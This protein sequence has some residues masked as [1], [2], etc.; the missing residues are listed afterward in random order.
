MILGFDWLI[1]NEAKIDLGD[2]KALIL[3]TGGGNKVVVPF[4]EK[5][6]EDSPGVNLQKEVLQKEIKTIE[7]I[8]NEAKIDLGDP[9]AL[10]LNTGGGNKVVV[11]FLE[12]VYEDSPGVNLQKE[13]NVTDP[14]EFFMR[15]CRWRSRL[16]PCNQLFYKEM[17]EWG[18]CCLTRTELFNSAEDDVDDTFINQ[19]LDL[20]IQ[21]SDKSDPNS[22]EF[23]T[24]YEGEQAVLPV[25]L[26][27]G[28]SYRAQLTYVEIKDSSK[29]KLID[30]D[31]VSAKDYSPEM[32]MIKC[33]EH[34]CRCS[35]PLTPL[36][37]DD[38]FPDCTVRQMN[39]LKTL[40]LDMHSCGCLP[41]CRK[42]S[43]Q[44]MLEG[45]P[46]SEIGHAIDPIF[47]EVNASSSVFSI[48]IRK[49]HSKRFDLMYNDT[50]WSLLSSLGGVFNMF[51]GVGLI[52][53]LEVM[54]FL[55][56]L[57]LACCRATQLTIPSVT[58][59]QIQ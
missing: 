7:S 37:N 49:N 39:C 38:E 41:S 28:Y 54:V 17:T 47:G 5:V 45:S 59:T 16:V 26:T 3:N 33:K 12:K 44:T 31:C 50:W 13:F 53:V 9:K 30:L 6:Y 8:A 36:T 55:V 22:F 15:V 57:P 25:A 27:R 29:E 46:I 40:N 1:A 56:R 35:D 23:Y 43:T 10:I 20:L 48:R 24:K 18:I 14:C 2:P 4:L 52:S 11:P 19:S 58:V 32:C 34:L 42:I 21:F 51:L